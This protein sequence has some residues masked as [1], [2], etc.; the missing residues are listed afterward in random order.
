MGISHRQDSPRTIGKNILQGL[1]WQSSAASDITSY[2]V[3]T[4]DRA[5]YRGEIVVRQPVIRDSSRSSLMV[6]DTLLRDV[7]VN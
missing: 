5:K 2:R 4:V 1:R 7:I 3:L 6:N